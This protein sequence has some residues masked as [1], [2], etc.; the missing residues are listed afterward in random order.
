MPTLNPPH[1]KVQTLPIKKL[2]FNNKNKKVVFFSA[3]NTE[4]K[5]EQRRG[6]QIIM[7]YLEAAK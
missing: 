4:L 5:Q 7:F 3:A 1:P 2:L 6:S